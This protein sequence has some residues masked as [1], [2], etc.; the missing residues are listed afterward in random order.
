MYTGTLNALL[1]ERVAMQAE[2][3]ND[4]SLMRDARESVEASW[5][6]LRLLSPSSA[7]LRRS[8]CSHG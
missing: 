3:E 6:A 1:R 8:S 5:E 2:R 4:R 7:L